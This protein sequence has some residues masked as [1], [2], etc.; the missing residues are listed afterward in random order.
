MNN[1][2][3]LHSIIQLNVVYI[4]LLFFSFFFNV[5]IRESVRICIYEKRLKER[6][7]ERE[8]GN[9]AFDKKK[10]KTL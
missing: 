6:E 8:K 2:I 10:E 7:R 4:H 3:Y 9:K 1:F 5:P